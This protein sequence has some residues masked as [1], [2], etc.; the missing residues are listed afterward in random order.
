MT[1]NF[2][3]AAIV[4]CCSS[5]REK[6]VC[7]DSRDRRATTALSVPKDQLELRAFVVMLDFQ[8]PTVQRAYE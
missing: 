2:L 8:E 3:L 4:R 6:S 7:Q 5:Y 1:Q